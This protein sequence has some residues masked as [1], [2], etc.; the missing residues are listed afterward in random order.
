[1]DHPPMDRPWIRTLFSGLLSE[2]TVTLISD[3]YD[4]YRD[5]P[6]TQLG[7]ESMAVMGLVVRMETEFGKEV[8]YEAF[9]LD[10]VSTLDR[11][12]EFL[13]VD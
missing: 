9:R 11:V 1:M 3:R 10:D 2:E 5:A 4:D 8:D 7:L 12:K 13:G 6:L